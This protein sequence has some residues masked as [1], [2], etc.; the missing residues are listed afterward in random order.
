MVEEFE[1]IEIGEIVLFERA[2]IIEKIK[3]NQNTRNS[4]KRKVEVVEIVEMPT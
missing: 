1:K 2:G 3:N 4:W